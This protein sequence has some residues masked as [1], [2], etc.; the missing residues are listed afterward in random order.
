[1]PTQTQYRQRFA[2][3]LRAYKPDEGGLA[4]GGTTST[5]IQANYPIQKN[6]DESSEFDDWF[7]LR[8]NAATV[9]GLYSDQVRTIN[10][11]MYAPRSGTFTVDR[12]YT[13]APT[14]DPYELHGHGFEPWNGI[15][16][17]LNAALRD[18]HVVVTVPFIPRVAASGNYAQNLTDGDGAHLVDTYIPAL[19]H[20][21]WVHAIDLQPTATVQTQTIAISG[22]PTSGTWT[23]SYRGIAYSGTIALAAVAATVQTALRTLPGLEAVTVAQ[24]GSGNNLTYTITMTGAPLQGPAISVT[25]NT[26]GG[27]HAIAVAITA[28]AGITVPQSGRV[29]MDGNHVIFYADRH[30]DSGDVLYIRCRLRAYDWCRASST[31]A[32]GSQS[33]LS[34]EAHQ[35]QPVVEWVSAMMQVWGWRRRPDLMQKGV[36]DRQ[37]AS[38]AQAQAMV[39]MYEDEF[40]RSIVRSPLLKYPVQGGEGPAGELGNLNPGA[41][42]ASLTAALSAGGNSQGG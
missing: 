24:S 31:A 41:S 9:G 11:G 42:G 30:Y 5:L 32:W 17:L 33:G 40:L 26:S 29:D 28:E 4:T 10:P 13:N 2:Q 12:P 22:T 1:M 25:D 18:I 19:L 36:Q 23:F 38:L 21:A 39:N 27:T 35:A 37:I 15:G 14:T 8:P 16:L 7:L 20:P 34:G 6:L 3:D